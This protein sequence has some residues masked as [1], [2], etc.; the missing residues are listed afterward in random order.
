MN[1]RSLSIVLGSF[2][3]ISMTLQTALAD[4]TEIYV[5]R[6]L[7]EDQQVRPNLMFVIDNSGSMLSNVPGTTCAVADRSIRNRC[8][9]VLI[10]QTCTRYDWRGRCDRWTNNYEYRKTRLQVVKDVTNELV[11]ELRLS[12]DVN[13]GLMHFDA[14]PNTSNEEGAM[15]AIAAGRA[16]TTAN[17]FIAELNR[18]YGASNTPLSES[19]YEAALYMKGAT[20][21][22][23]NGTNAAYEDGNSWTNPSKPSVAAS[24]SGST[25]KSPIQYHIA[26][27][28]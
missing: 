16:S 2:C 11:E 6:K 26:N 5:S 12:D 9:E 19:F 1:I 14:A 22:F 25:Y 15:V 8:E 13:I 23:G 27:R 28:R 21:K 4:D 3:Y 18:L 20:P 10:S 7:P 24:K 17:S